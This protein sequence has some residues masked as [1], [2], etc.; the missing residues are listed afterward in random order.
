MKRSGP[1]QRKTPM[2]RTGT[3]KPGGTTRKVRTRPKRSAQNRDWTAARAKVAIE[4]RCRVCG[5]DRNVQA[6]HVIGRRHD[7]MGPDGRIFVD[8]LEI[9]PLC[10]ECHDR[11]DG[12]AHGERL[13]LLPYLTLLEQAAAVALVG[14][15]VARKRLTGKRVVQ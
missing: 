11:Y 4:R 13:D 6:A 3:L 7:R 9:V 14:L 15:E 10:L 5:S 2:R 8:P 12:R 1:I